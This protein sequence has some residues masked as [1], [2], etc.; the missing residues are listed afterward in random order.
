VVR[1]SDV[2][3]L[4]GNLGDHTYTWRNVHSSIHV[5]VNN[6]IDQ[7]VIPSPLCYTLN[8]RPSPK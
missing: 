8:P 1:V 7:N 3:G 4:S 2:S 5:V 6:P